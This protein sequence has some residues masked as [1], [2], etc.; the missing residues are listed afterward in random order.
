[1][2]TTIGSSRS[3]GNAPGYANH[4]QRRRRQKSIGQDRGVVPHTIGRN[5]QDDFGR[6]C[7][8]RSYP[9]CNPGLLVSLRLGNAT[10]GQPEGLIN[11]GLSDDEPA[12]L[13]QAP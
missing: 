9:A 10:T 13:L 8:H 3:Q 2:D 1:M 7:P 12:C 4:W 5:W 6:A 11:P